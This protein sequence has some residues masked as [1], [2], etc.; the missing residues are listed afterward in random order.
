[1]VDIPLIL[2]VSST[3]K[4]EK[5]FYWAVL[6]KLPGQTDDILEVHSETSRFDHLANK[7]ESKDVEVIKRRS[8]CR[9]W[10]LRQIV[11]RKCIKLTQQFSANTCYPVFLETNSKFIFQVLNTQKIENFGNV[12]RKLSRNGRTEWLTDW[13]THRP[14]DRPTGR[15][16]DRPA[17]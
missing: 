8:G 15:G 11:R 13:L 5:E 6:E 4:K 9:S 7:R 1:M 12:L 3:N 16:I 17:D 10:T 14:T 2:T